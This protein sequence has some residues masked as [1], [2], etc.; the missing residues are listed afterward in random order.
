[1]RPVDQLGPDELETVAQAYHEL[2]RRSSPAGSVAATPW[3]ELSEDDRAANRASAEAVLG[4]VADMGY[5]AVR[6]EGPV[7]AAPIPPDVVEAASIREHDRWAAFKRSQGW[8]HGPVRDPTARTH[9]DLVPWAA[10]DE[11]TREKDRVRMRIIPDLLA[12]VGVELV[13]ASDRTGPPDQSV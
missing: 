8:R 11:P 2:Y 13:L 7:V 12:T 5:E 1:M 3:T 4:H 10:L 6:S 9:P